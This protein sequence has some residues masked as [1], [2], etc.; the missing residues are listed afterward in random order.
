MIK[1]FL[2]KLLAR[3]GL[4]LRRRPFK[5]GNVNVNKSFTMA[6]G[7]QRCLA[8]GLSVKTVIDVGASDGRWSKLCAQSYPDAHYL[9]VEA[10]QEHQDRLEVYCKSHPHA[11]YTIAAAG[12]EDGTVYFDNA[13]LF[14]GLASIDPLNNNHEVAAISLDNEVVRRGFEPPY[15]LK[16]DTHGFEVPILEG[17]TAILQE[18]SLVI[19]ETYN[20]QLTSNSLRYY[21]MCQYMETLGFYPI[22]MVDFTLRA[23]DHS[24]WQMDTFFVKK[25]DKA[26]TH[27]SY[28]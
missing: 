28:Q 15:L 12:P 11:V 14:G 23:Y 16:L 8:R 7:L 13:D 10:Q 1:N 18:A 24:F 2:N 22:E 9:L 27:H 17:A 21:E 20:Y 6:G 26:F 5:T 25:T 19:I 3:F 4:E